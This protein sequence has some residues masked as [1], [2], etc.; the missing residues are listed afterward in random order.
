MA[1]RD[2]SRRLRYTII[3]IESPGHAL[4]VVVLSH[5]K[6][7]SRPPGTRCWQPVT[8]QPVHHILIVT[9]DE[10]LSVIS[11]SE[12][13]LLAISERTRSVNKFTPLRGHLQSS[14]T[15]GHSEFNNI[16]SCNRRKPVFHHL[17][18]F[19]HVSTQQRLSFACSHRHPTPQCDNSEPAKPVSRSTIH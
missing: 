10:S 5:E 9:Q 15:T 19:H 16:S 1:F 11:S 13:D 3:I 2:L 14:P 18:I 12:P 8:L 4:V 17:T 6:R 7:M